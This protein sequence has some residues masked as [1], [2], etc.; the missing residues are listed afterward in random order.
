MASVLF[1]SHNESFYERPIAEVIKTE[2]EDSTPVSDMYSNDDQ[3]FTQ[4]ITALVKNG[5]DKGQ[6]II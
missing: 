2:L 1:V 5:E 3:L 6:L 4:Q